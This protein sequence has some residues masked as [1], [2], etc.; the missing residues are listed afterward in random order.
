MILASNCPKMLQKTKFKL[1]VEFKMKILGEPKI[2][3]SM[4]IKRDRE[5]Q[6][7]TLTQSEYTENCLEKFGMNEC[8]PM[9]TLG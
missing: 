5:S 4:K 1:S 3:L 8:A 2:F 7:I 9:C 6:I